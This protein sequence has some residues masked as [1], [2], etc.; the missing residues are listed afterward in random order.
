MG[1]LK[2]EV[3]PTKYEIKHAVQ[4]LFPKDKVKKANRE[5]DKVEVDQVLLINKEEVK[6]ATEKLRSKKTP[7]P[8][9]IPREVVKALK[10]VMLEEIESILNKEL[11]AGK[12]PATWKKAELVANS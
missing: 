11:L 5:L 2:R 1:K 4:E 10:H 8:D 9:G 12:F 3:P 7:G 6:K